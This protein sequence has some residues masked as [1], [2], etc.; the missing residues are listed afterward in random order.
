MTIHNET[1]TTPSPPSTAP[2][3]N[4]TTESNASDSSEMESEVNKQQQ[5]QQQEPNNNATTLI[6]TTTHPNRASTSDNESVKTGDVKCN[7]Y[8]RK[9]HIRYVFISTL[10]TS[11]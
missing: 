8:E 5:Q 9:F 10:L 3:P 7:I 2:S 1:R 11:N 4:D 6:P